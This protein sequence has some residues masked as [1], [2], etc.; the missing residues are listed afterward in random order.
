MIQVLTIPLYLYTSSKYIVW[1]V[2]LG[3]FIKSIYLSVKLLVS[4]T[5]ADP[6]VGITRWRVIPFSHATDTVFTCK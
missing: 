3:G 2:R 6:A 4:V 5:I 1:S